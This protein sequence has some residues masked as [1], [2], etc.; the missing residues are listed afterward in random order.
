MFFLR[1]LTDTPPHVRCV[2]KDRRSFLLF[3]GLLRPIG[4]I[5]HGQMGTR[6]KKLKMRFAPLRPH[7]GGCAFSAAK[8]FAASVSG[9]GFRRQTRPRTGELPVAAF[10]KNI[11]FSPAVLPW[12]LAGKSRCVEPAWQQKGA[13]SGKARGCAAETFL[14]W[15]QSCR[16]GGTIFP[17]PNGS[18]SIIV[19]SASRQPSAIR[20][21]SSGALSTI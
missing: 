15:R 12:R 13:S 6:R 19:S 9:K 4:K 10:C 11:S 16:Y 7:G 21:W 3:G 17:C 18:D 5:S 1:E 20:V 2:R 8:S 14:E